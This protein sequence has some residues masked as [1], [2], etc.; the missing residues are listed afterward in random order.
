MLY[1]FIILYH[2]FQCRFFR[3]QK[4]KFSAIS[5]N[6]AN[7]LHKKPHPRQKV[8]PTAE[9]SL[10]G[11]LNSRYSTHIFTNLFVTMPP[12]VMIFTT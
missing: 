12:Y 11:L 10:G 9:Y 2:S 4:Y 5:E 1:Y 8:Q 7:Y 6:I 3:L